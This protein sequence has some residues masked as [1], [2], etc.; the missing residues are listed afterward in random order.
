MVGVRIMSRLMDATEG[1]RWVLGMPV[2][3]KTPA[4][5]RDERDRQLISDA[6]DVAADIVDIDRSVAGMLTDLASAL[7]RRLESA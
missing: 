2:T 1:V 4:Q 5:E 3:P 7:E 6:Q